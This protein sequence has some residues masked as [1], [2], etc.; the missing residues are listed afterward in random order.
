MAPVADSYCLLL[1]RHINRYPNKFLQQGFFW[2][3]GADTG[4][5]FYDAAFAFQA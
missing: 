2:C 5:I 4:D 3:P 1:R